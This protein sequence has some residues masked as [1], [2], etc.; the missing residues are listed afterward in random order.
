MVKVIGDLIGRT[1]NTAEFPVVIVEGNTVK[2]FNNP[3]AIANLVTTADVK[4]GLLV[5]FDSLGRQMNIH[6]RSG[7]PAVSAAEN[8]PTRGAEL[9]HHISM[10]LS[11]HNVDL[12]EVESTSL[13]DLVS[14]L[15]EVGD[16]YWQKGIE[17]PIVVLDGGTVTLI[18]R[19]EQLGSSMEGQDV[20]T[21]AYMA[22]DR[23]G[24]PLRLFTVEGIPTVSTG[25]TESAES[26]RLRSKL[27]RY[28]PTPVDEA[29]AE[30]ATVEDLIKRVSD[31]G[32][33]YY[34]GW[35]R[36]W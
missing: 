5:A 13:S 19:P 23:H 26:G 3:R 31:G 17:Y 29:W 36:D 14:K 35:D 27:I 1:A 15:F 10:Y 11:Q 32:L 8:L 34:D 33:A 2:A 4:S 18:K 24:L 12:S 9:R 28:L 25:G 6:V 22:F 16:A 30:S 20:D 21:G 7:R